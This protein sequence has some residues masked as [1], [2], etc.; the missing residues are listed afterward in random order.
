MAGWARNETSSFVNLS[1]LYGNH[2]VKQGMV[3]KKVGRG[4]LQNEVFTEGWLLL[5]PPIACALLVPYRRQHNYIA[6]VLYC[7]Q[8]DCSIPQYPDNT[9]LGL[10]EAEIILIDGFRCVKCLILRLGMR[11]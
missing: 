5:L 8:A 9:C 7:T 3:R 4:K 6:C 2:Q 1:P 10:V 11:R